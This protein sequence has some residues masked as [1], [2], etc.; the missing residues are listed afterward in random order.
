L[1]Q[2]PCRLCRD[3][4]GRG[5]GE[6]RARSAPPRTALAVDLDQVARIVSNYERHHQL[7]TDQ[8]HPN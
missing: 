2:P 6:G 3:R 1:W 8:P 7:G 4:A 5:S